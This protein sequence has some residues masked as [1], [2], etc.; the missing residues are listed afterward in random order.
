[1]APIMRLAILLEVRSQKVTIGNN[2]GPS[3]QRQPVNNKVSAKRETCDLS[4]LVETDGCIVAY[5]PASLVSTNWY[6]S[7]GSSNV[8]S[9]QD[10][11]RH[12]K[13]TTREPAA[14]EPTSGMPRWISTAG[15]NSSFISY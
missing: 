6:I 7:S 9:V 2:I 4:I 12:I 5:A 15:S 14:E 1:M 10:S 3:G 13:K 8:S 11:M